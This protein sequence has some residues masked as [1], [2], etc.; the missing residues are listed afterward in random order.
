M[1]KKRRRRKDKNI[2]MKILDQK[3]I[4]EEKKNKRKE[5]RILTEKNSEIDEK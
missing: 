3:Q 4:K 1:G 5:N 2:K